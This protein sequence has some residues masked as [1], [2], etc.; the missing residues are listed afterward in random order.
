MS[1]SNCPDTNRNNQQLYMSAHIAAQKCDSGQRLFV[2]GFRNKVYSICYYF[3]A[4]PKM[5]EH[6]RNVQF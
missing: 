6:I 1:V 2:K 4:E 5:L 3:R